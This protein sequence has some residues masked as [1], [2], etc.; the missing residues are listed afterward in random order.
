[1]LLESLEIYRNAPG[2]ESR[3]AITKSVLG[4][5]LAALERF[6]EAEPLLLGGHAKLE[7]MHGANH[8]NTLK[9]LRRVIEAHEAW[10]KPEHAA[11]WGVK[12]TTTRPARA[13]TV[14]PAS[15]EG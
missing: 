3:A 4:G 7:A 8:Q 15:E 10:G 9:A 13:E 6:E 2:Q 14:P 11:E 12:L 1:M 5:C